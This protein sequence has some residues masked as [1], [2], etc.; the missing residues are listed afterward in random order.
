[1]ADSGWVVVG[2]LLRTRGRNGE[3]LAAIDSSQPGR[4][5]R[6]A[7]VLL[8][9]V[10]REAHFDVERFWRHDGCPV[11]KFAG[12]DSISEAEL[13]EGSE[14]LVPEADRAAP[15]PGEFYQADLI[16]CTVESRSGILGA[17][18]GLDETGGGPL[19]LRV[20]ATDGRE[21]LIPFARAICKE[22]DVAGKR[23]RVELP[24]GLTE[25]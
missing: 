6:I 20:A 13:W 18:T 2:R 1:L 16:G 9:R 10:D 8:R 23:I 22:I 3:L 24:E 21:I 14:I 7:R 25:L 4:A 11:F 12:I 17:V 19:L 15:E 5:E